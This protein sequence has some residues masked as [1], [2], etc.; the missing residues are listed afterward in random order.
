MT[1]SN[2]MYTHRQVQSVSR[3]VYN[4]EFVGTAL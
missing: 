1:M 4:N 3:D 2:V